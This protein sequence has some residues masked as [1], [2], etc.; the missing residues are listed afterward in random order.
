MERLENLN[1]DKDIRLKYFANLVSIPLTNTDGIKWPIR[2][3]EIITPVNHIF[4]S[5]YVRQV[6]QLRFNYSENE[7]HK[8]FNNSL[9]LWRYSH[10]VINGLEKAGIEKST[11]SEFIETIM[12]MVSVLSENNDFIEGKHLVLNKKAVNY[13][14]EKPFIRDKQMNLNLLKLAAL[15]WAYSDALYFQGRE[16]CCEYHGPYSLNENGDI[17]L[18]RDFCNF[19]PDDLWT[20]YEFDKSI[21]SIRIITQ[22]NDSMEAYIDVYNNVNIKKGSMAESITGG[23]MIIDGIVADS[24]MINS[25]IVR[26]VDMLKKQTIFVNG[27]SKDDLFSK[28]LMIFWYRKKVLASFLGENWTPPMIVFDIIKNTEIIHHKENPYKNVSIESLI[29][30]YDYSSFLH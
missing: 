3:G 22:H 6:F 2:S 10:H 29:R 24:H 15:L 28:Y 9:S 8:A 21:Q 11:I 17:L 26:F 5:E 1:V 7:W 25:L 4:A 23:L 14:L 20:E 12:E 30:K 13:M 18:V 16:I 27:M 19:Y